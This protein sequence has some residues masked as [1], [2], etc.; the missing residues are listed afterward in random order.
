MLNKDEK[1]GLAKD[2]KRLADLTTPEVLTSQEELD[3]QFFAA[4][5][6]NWAADHCQIIDK[7]GTRKPFRFNHA[8]LHTNG[9]I[10]EMQKVG[11]P[12]R[13]VHL[14]ARQLGE[15]TRG[16]SR[17]YQHSNMWPNRRALISAHDKD[18]SVQIFRKVQLFQTYNP[19]KLPSQYSTRLE[20]TFEPPHHSSI[21]VQTAGK[22]SLGR[23]S[24]YDDI[25]LSEVAFFDHAEQTML[26][27]HQC[28]PDSPNTMVVAE[29]TANGAGGYFFKL[30]NNAKKADCDRGKT[31]MT[32]PEPSKDDWNGYYRVFHPWFVDEEYRKPAPP[33]FEL[34]DLEVTLKETFGVDNDQLCWRRWTINN[35]CNGDLDL[36]DQEYPATDRDAF[37][38]S[39]R[40]VFSP[41]LID[42][43]MKYV[44]TPHAVGAFIEVKKGYVELQT[45]EAAG[46]WVKIW[47]HPIDDH[48]YAI[49]ADTAE[50]KDPEESKNPDANSA[51]VID[52][53]TGMVVAKLDGQMD[54]DV[55]SEQLDYLG[56]YYNM[57]YLGVEV[58]NT[59]GGATRQ[60]LKS[61]NYPNMH[62]RQ[63]YNRL[64][65]DMTLVVGFET[66]KQTRMMILTG[67]EGLAR[68][69]REDR[70]KI[71]DEQTLYQLR[72]FVYNK[73]G[74]PEATKGE[75]DDDVMSLAI[76]WHMTQLAAY[77]GLNELPEETGETKGTSFT[78][79]VTAMGQKSTIMNG[80]SFLI[81]GYEK[82]DEQLMATSRHPNDGE[83]PDDDNPW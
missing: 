44:K 83:V 54:P 9:I 62:Y 37:L 58:N 59:S 49:G 8:Q 47:Q 35:K 43:N 27:V 42:R 31:Y 57:A 68:A 12:V 75:H 25:H 34:N 40:P 76:A 1:T 10:E 65:D 73:D 36:F 26:A 53:M 81:G 30:Y 55:F 66:N 45:A 15:T 16:C 63:V 38:V 18:S 67:G 7:H 3:A 22:E 46:N 51:H 21:L 82:T 78:L 19:Q 56:Q 28:V 17:I 4:W 20:L 80:T 48:L 23:G 50:G 39:G 64:T 60:A 74:K 41:H 70:I 77:S 5:P 2:E 33:D 14:K 61:R 13:I 24:T 11:L 32:I 6:P 29:S 52:V 71:Y 72:C 69:I 79:P